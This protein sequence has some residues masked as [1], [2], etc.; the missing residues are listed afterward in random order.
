M[1]TATRL[2][3]FC[4]ERGP[5]ND[6]VNINGGWFH[7]VSAAVKYGQEGAIKRE[8][9]EARK[10]KKRFKDMSKPHQE[11]LTQE[12]CN[13]LVRMLDYGK[14][15]ISCGETKPLEAGHF[16]SVGSCPE[17]R[18]ELLNIH[19]QCRACNQA[20]TRKMNRGRK[21]EV[22]SA[23]YEKRLR[24]RLGDAVVDWLNGP[25][26][27]PKHT[28]EELK[29]MRAMY[30]AEQKYIEQYGRPS[31]NWRSFPPKEEAA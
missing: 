17:L 31:R 22:V 5:V 20:G 2:C 23:E 19:G 18:F 30:V 1:P 11:K 29:I 3:R 21:P 28:C 9:Q 15:C 24:A 7:N 27:M 12:Q 16:R 10:Q 13:K 26:E 25:N 4:K 8:K 14:P 6:M